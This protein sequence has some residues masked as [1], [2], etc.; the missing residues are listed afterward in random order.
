V[1]WLVGWLVGFDR[2]TTAEE[3][4]DV[5]RQSANYNWLESRCHT[6]LKKTK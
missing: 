2:Y 3:E 6:S 4:E 5:Y 1:S